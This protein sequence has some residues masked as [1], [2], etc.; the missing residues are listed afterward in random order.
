MNCITG[1]NIKVKDFI[2]SNTNPII[3]WKID[4]SI[5]NDKN[6]VPEHLL[7]KCVSDWKVNLWEGII[8]IKSECC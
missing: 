3:Q 4:G 6:F 2:L 5:F 8:E 1:E 7:E